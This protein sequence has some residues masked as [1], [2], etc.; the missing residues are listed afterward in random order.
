MIRVALVPRDRARLHEAIATR[1]DSMLALG[2]VDELRQ[3]RARFALAPTL[4]SM[5]S[6]GYRQTWDFLDGRIDEATLRAKGVAA[7]RQLAKRQ[8]TWLR[9]LRM[10]AFE[11]ETP[12][13]VDDVLALLS[14]PLDEGRREPEAVGRGP[15]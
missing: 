4:P 12:T 11:P 15:I 13:L 8:F 5:R 3:L 1:F 2:L 14:A 9:S 6:V 10:P 7:T